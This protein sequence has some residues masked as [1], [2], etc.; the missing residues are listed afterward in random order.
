MRE[1]RSL[2]A[3][4]DEY[5]Q[6]NTK[7]LEDLM[8]AWKG[9]KELPPGEPTSFF[10][11]GGYHGEPFRGA[12]WGVSQNIFWGGYCHHGNVLFPLWH[13]AYVY[14]IEEALRSVPGC[15]DVTIPFW[16]ECSAESLNKGIPWSLTVEEFELDGETIPNPLRSYVLPAAIVD[17][18]SG[19]VPNYSKQAGYETVRYPFS[20]LVGS[21]AERAET[22]QHNEQWSPAEGVTELDRNIIEWLN[23]EIEIEGKQVTIGIHKAFTQCLD[24]PHYTLFSNTTSMEAWND[25]GPQVIAL[26]NPHNKMHLAVGGFDVPGQPSRSLIRGANGDM[27]ENDTAALDPIF[28]FH[29]CFIDRVFWLWQLRNQATDELSIFEGYPGTNSSDSQGATPGVAPN[30]WLSL[31]TPL[32]PF[33]WPLG[34]E[35]RTVTGR[36]LFNIETQLEYTYGE[37][38]LEDLPGP[39]PEQLASAAG[40]P[41][42]HVSGIDRGGIRGSFLIVASAEIEGERKVIGSEAVL[43]RWHVGGCANC[44]T[45][46]MAGA[47]FPLHGLD[48]DRLPPDALKVEVRTR[49]GLLGDRPHGLSALEG[50][51]S[52]LFRVELRRGTANAGGARPV[53]ST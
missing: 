48:L 31:D 13:R 17:H 29:H 34:D 8:R 16:D 1:R 36:D 12:G 15:E 3:L 7:P 25:N 28:Y 5:A 41:K 33:V 53:S 40:E 30:Q 46:L 24:A 10:R 47:S 2:T 4:E 37:G 21:E 32:D 9:I 27:G 38:S 20:G 42:L 35:E 14:A 45:H 22:K 26:E 44:Q 43:S 11:I 51:E 49:D 19:D 50:E 18:I 52:S 39:S 23:E 6:G